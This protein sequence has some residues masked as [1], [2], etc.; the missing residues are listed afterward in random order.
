[1]SPPLCPRGHGHETNNPVNSQLTNRLGRDNAAGDDA[2]TLK[3]NGIP[4]IGSLDDA[5]QQVQAMTRTRGGSTA[6]TAMERMGM[7]AQTPRPRQVLNQTKATPKPRSANASV[8]TVVPSKRGS[9]SGATR[10]ALGL[11]AQSARGENTRP[12]SPPK[13]STPPVSAKPSARPAASPTVR[14]AQPAPTKPMVTNAAAPSVPKTNP[15]P[16]PKQSW[17]DKF[18]ADHKLSADKSYTD[19]KKLMESV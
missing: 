12:T 4:K 11:P 8:N 15:P 18:S 1:M 9:M 6:G 5:Q 3:P 2:M 16:A 7:P 14:K 17:W 19:Y 13:R 10:G